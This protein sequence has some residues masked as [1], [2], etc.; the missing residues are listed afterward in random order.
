MSADAVPPPPD[1]AR[2][3]SLW[4][5][6]ERGVSSPGQ[7]MSDLK[8]AGLRQLLEGTVAVHEEAFGGSTPAE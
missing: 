2:L 6:W 1:P 4:M 3:L 5:E 8:K 7:V